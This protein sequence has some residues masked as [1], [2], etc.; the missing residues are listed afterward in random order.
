MTEAP[1]AP[2]RNRPRTPVG[3]C[4]LVLTITPEGRRPAAYL[5]RPLSPDRESGVLKACELVKLG[6]YEERYAVAWTAEGHQ[7]SCPD[8]SFHREGIDPGGC[9]HIRALIAANYL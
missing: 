9:K 4:R 8:F 3:T 6:G 7:C 5:V 1:P 2:S